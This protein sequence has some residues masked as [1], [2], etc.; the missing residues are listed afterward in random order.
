MLQTLRY[1][2]AAHSGLTECELLDVLSCND[3]LLRLLLPQGAGELR[4]PYP[5]WHDIR[6]QLGIAL[7]RVR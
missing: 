1:L 5:L 2:T 7:C 6:T 4:Y 3:A